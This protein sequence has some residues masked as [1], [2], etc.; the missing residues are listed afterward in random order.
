M[1][2]SISQKLIVQKHQRQQKV[3]VRC[4][5]DNTRIKIYVNNW[6]TMLHSRK[7][8]CIGEIT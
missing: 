3:G 8:N 7:K 5:T 4:G 6:V 1:P 2:S